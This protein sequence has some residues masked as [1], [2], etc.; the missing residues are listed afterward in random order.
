MQTDR[1]EGRILWIDAGAGAAGDMIL[2]ALIDLGVP[3]RRIRDAIGT[4]G[5]DGWSI[6]PRKTVVGGI[7]ARKVHVRVPEEGHGRTWPQIS[8]ILGS[9]GL[10]PAVRKRALEI[11]R[12]LIEAE[13]EVHGQPVEKVHLHE[14]G[15][16]DAIIDVVGACVGLAC[17]GPDRIVVSPMTTGSG[18]VR[19]KHGEYPVP[20]PATAL[21]VLNAPVTSANLPGERLTP[22][23]AAILTTI[24]DDYGTLPLLR[25]VRIGYGAGDRDFGDRPNLL[26]M[27]LGQGTAGD[28]PASLPETAVIECTIDDSNPQVLAYASERLFSAGALEVYSVDALM[29]KGRAGRQLTVLA[30]PGELRGIVEVL[31]RETS[32]LGLRIR[33]EKRV[34]MDRSYH[35]V[36]TPHGAVTVKTG[37]IG[38][39]EY[40]AWPEYEECAAIAVK[41]GIPLSQVQNEALEAY[42]A[43]RKK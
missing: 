27:V 25:P 18:T 39:V 11:F 36:R 21:L 23:G 2:G 17:L 41:H 13:A 28:M 15:A 8:R 16:M 3:A 31:L 37:S 6:R 26:R 42:R 32:T 33:T 10:E 7:S 43:V 40:Q 38:G 14:A 9:G 24:A 20:A 1:K 34:E 5:I 4:L 29:K 35:K 22:T 30:R 12:R 19:C